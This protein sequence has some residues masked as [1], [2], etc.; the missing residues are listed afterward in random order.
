M[1]VEGISVNREVA[2][3]TFLRVSGAAALAATA[4]APQ[5]PPP[6]APPA[7]SAA[8]APSAPAWESEWNELVAAAKREGKVVLAGAPGQRFW[9]D[10]FQTAFPEITVELEDFAS[11]QLQVKKVVAE[12]E[13]GIYV[14][15]TTVT[16]TPVILAGYKPIG[17]LAP[18]GPSLIKRPDIVDDKNWTRGFGAGWMD[19]D[20][21]L[22][23]ACSET[24]GG[25]VLVNT[26]LVGAGDI[27][28]VDDLLNPKWKGQI[29]WGAKGTTTVF[30]P[31]TALRLAKGDEFA[32][33]LIV[34]QRALFLV[35]TQMTEELVRGRYPI[36]IS[37][38]PS[39]LLKYT[40]QGL[41]K[42]L[43]YL[44]FP[45]LTFLNT[46]GAWM[47]NRAPHPNAAK[48]FMHWSLTKACGDALVAQTFNP[49]RS[50]SGTPVPI[51]A[52]KPGRKYTVVDVEDMLPEVTRSNELVEQWARQL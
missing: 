20:K 27:K 14:R 23:N 26:D 3:R 2:R 43:K 31:V 22:S 42:N 46:W 12:R 24:V 40:D 9:V 33:R 15:D 45:E 28:T 18:F 10:A 49:R 52:P 32:K 4:C 35:T 16:A 51:A 13:A 36:S 30:G 29:V 25:H 48:L 7:Q 38:S 19:K 8:S 44:D 39:N 50:D 21:Q 34:D 41:G 37:L 17:A 47:F 1:A 6:P 5:A 11:S